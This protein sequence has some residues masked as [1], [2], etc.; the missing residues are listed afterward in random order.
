MKLKTTF[1]KIRVPLSFVVAILF[2]IFAR[3]KKPYFYIGIPIGISGLFIRLW[4][5]GHIVKSKKL[6]KSGPYQYTRNPLYLGSFLIGSGLSIQCGIIFFLIFLTLF[7]IIYIPVIKRE[8]EEMEQVFGNDFNSY[9]NS[10]PLFFP[11]FL[12][13]IKD[14]GKFDINQM[15][16][17]REYKGIIAFLII[18]II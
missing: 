7:A 8:E 5:A 18:E 10:V 11:N 2:L 6:T 1:Q 16:K 17:N 15:L 9:K 4:A 12:K 13:K 3:P 14:N